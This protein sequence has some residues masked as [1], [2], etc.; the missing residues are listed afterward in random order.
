MLLHRCARRANEIKKMKRSRDHTAAWHH[1]PWEVAR[2][3]QAAGAV[4]PSAPTFVCPVYF[5]GVISRLFAQWLVKVLLARARRSLSRLRKRAAGGADGAPNYLMPPRVLLGSAVHAYR[6]LIAA[7]FSQDSGEP[8]E[9]PVHDLIFPS[10]CSVMKRGGKPFFASNA[11][12]YEIGLVWFKMRYGL[13][14]RES[15]SSPA[16][17]AFLASIK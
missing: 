12:I 16:D 17:C 2:A 4:A 1:K 9:Y 14:R 5:V 11:F 6:A 7:L 13:W 15:F 8:F 10:I 3:G